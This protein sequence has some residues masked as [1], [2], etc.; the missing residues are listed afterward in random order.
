MQVKKFEAKTM[1]EA[2][3]L[4]KKELGPEAVILSARDNKKGFVQKKGGV[5][6]S[7]AANTG[8]S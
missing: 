5:Y 2:L 8:K 7:A 4:V 1:K 6:G 3:E